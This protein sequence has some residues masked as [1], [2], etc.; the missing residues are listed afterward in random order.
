MLQL[1]FYISYYLYKLV[2]AM[3]RWRGK[4]AV[5][6]G[7]SAGIGEAIAKDLV[8]AGLI[9]VGLARR[10]E[11]MEVGIVIFLFYHQYLARVTPGIEKRDI[12]LSFDIFYLD[13]FRS[14]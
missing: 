3:D 12:T 5:V 10:K 1:L 11:R 13:L 7:A 4:V 8:E 14:S 9:V 2:S 6:T